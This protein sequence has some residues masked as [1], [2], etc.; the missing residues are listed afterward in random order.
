[1]VEPGDYVEAKIP[2]P[3]GA[4]L[5]VHWRARTGLILGHHFVACPDCHAQHQTPDQPM[6]LFQLKAYEWVEVPLE[7][8]KS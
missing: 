5:L 8:K 7:E 1:M 4:Q 6:R 2:C 3:C